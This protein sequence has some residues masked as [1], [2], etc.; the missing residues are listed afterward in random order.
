M[1]FAFMKKGI[2]NVRNYRPDSQ[3]VFVYFSSLRVS[4]HGLI[5]AF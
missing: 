4:S 2:I 1:F 5:L 3:E